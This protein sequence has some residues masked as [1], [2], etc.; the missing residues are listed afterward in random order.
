MVN[1]FVK[2]MIF[3]TYIITNITTLLINSNCCICAKNKILRNQFINL[4]EFIT[5]KY[6]FVFGN[7][8]ESEAKY[9]C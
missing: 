3:D 2:Y 1:Q 9:V 7:E 5:H 4:I 6:I 8:L